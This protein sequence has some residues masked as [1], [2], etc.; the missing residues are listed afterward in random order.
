MFAT[1][2]PLVGSGRTPSTRVG[3]TPVVQYVWAA[4][5][6]SIGWIFLWAFLDKL[7]GLGHATASARSWLNGGS[8]TNGFLAHAT[9]PFAGIYH[10]M[11]GDALWDWLFM[12]ALI[13]IGAALILGIGM[14]VAT[15][16]GVVLLVL[17]WSAA[18]PSANNIFMDEHLIYAITL[19]GL[20]LVGAGRTVGLGEAW[21]RTTLVRRLPWLA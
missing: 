17:M 16:S 5:R 19:V 14:R 21:S 9:G 2:T 1:Q 20:F 4:A 18:L 8:P 15:I 12:A 6:I 3:R 11:A 10:S 13:G 7:F